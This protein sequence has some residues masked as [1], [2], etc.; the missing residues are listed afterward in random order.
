MPLLWRDQVIG[1]GNLAVREGALHAE[2]GYVG[3][4]PPESSATATALHTELTAMAD[5]L[6]SPPEACRSP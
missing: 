6:G 1:W 3:G 5:F 4:Q 2:L